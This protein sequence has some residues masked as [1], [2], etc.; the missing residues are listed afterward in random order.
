M[1]RLMEENIS[2]F[3]QKHGLTDDEAYI[4]LLLMEASRRYGMLPESYATSN[5]EWADAA[6]RLESLMMRRVI[7]R[8][9]PEGWLTWE[10]IED[11]EGGAQEQ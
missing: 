9:Y 10:E 8:D 2:D 1:M 7:K 4:V 3:A 6:Q 5:V 11:R